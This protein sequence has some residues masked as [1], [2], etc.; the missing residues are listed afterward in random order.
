MCC[1]GLASLGRLGVGTQ[2]RAKTK[3][4]LRAERKRNKRLKEKELAKLRAK[5][6]EREKSIPDFSGLPFE[7]ATLPN[8]DRVGDDRAR[9][10]FTPVRIKAGFACQVSAG[11]A[12]GGAVTEDGQL[13]MWGCARHGRL[14]LPQ[15][16][17]MPCDAEDGHD[18][19]YPSPVPVDFPGAKVR[20]VAC[21]AKHTLACDDKGAIFAWGLG[22]YGRL[23]FGE[24]EMREL[25]V[26]EP[27][28]DGAWDEHSWHQ[29]KP[30]P[31]LSLQG[32]RVTRVYAGAYNSFAISGGAGTPPAV[33]SWGLARYGMLGIGDF[34]S[35]CC[36]QKR[37]DPDVPAAQCTLCIKRLAPPRE[38]GVPTYIE[39]RRGHPP[40][41]RV[42]AAFPRE[43]AKLHDLPA[44]PQD[45]LD[46]YCPTPCEVQQLAARAIVSIEAGVYHHFAVS[47]SGKLFAWGLL[48]HGRCG[49]GKFDPDG[50]V[51]AATGRARTD[52][53]VPTY[54]KERGFEL[55]SRGQIRIVEDDP[56]SWYIGE[57]KEVAGFHGARVV[58]VSAGEC[59][60][61][62]VT[63]DN[64]L[65]TWG[66]A[67]H[68]RLGT[69]EAR[70]ELLADP[71]DA[72]GWYRAEPREVDVATETQPRLVVC[73][74]SGT[75][76]AAREMT[77]K[78]K[79]RHRS[80]HAKGKLHQMGS[81]FAGELTRRLSDAGS[82]TRRLSI[83]SIRV[84]LC[85]LILQS[86]SPLGSDAV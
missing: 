30:R 15:T 48:R 80:K 68:G 9:F 25:P 32:I 10:L 37:F 11:L 84:P 41:A 55:N 82:V 19:Y 75:L 6:R 70:S 61:A 4:E 56:C 69:R 44:D 49:I 5:E 81:A 86:L 35:T 63:E 78:W 77:E 1:H 39:E 62:A 43:V 59:H 65:Y 7:I 73:T 23:G 46:V 22:R 72:E 33:Y 12:H 13:F 85:T 34:P 45:P 42:L 64:K 66:V 21:G 24:D 52:R 20:Y 79:E 83:D 18:T 16:L 58:R 2:R 36:H 31:I 27:D 40:F 17:G 8:G 47:S 50:H 51:N 76:F 60:S 29:L 26:E 3:K 57:P 54:S 28:E 71:H 53:T 38:G 74:S 14:G 67:R